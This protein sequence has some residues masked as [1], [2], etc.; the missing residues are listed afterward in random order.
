MTTTTSRPTMNEST[1]SQRWFAWLWR[2]LDS[3]VDQAVEPA[4]AR[5][6]QNLPDRVVEIG[7][8][9]GSTFKRYRPGTKVTAFE[10]NVFMHDELREAATKRGIEL[11]LRGAGAENM[12]LPDESQD[13]VVSSLT[14]CSVS[15]PVAVVSEIQRIL[16]PGGR[17]VFV[18]HIAAHDGSATAFAQ[19][20]LRRPWAALIGRC[21]LMPNTRRDIANAGFSEVHGDVAD[22]GSKLDPSRRTF[23]GYAVK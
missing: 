6:F 16:K 10:P 12:N 9:I 8:G 2:H 15:D 14:L 21:D 5:V 23:Y 22:L 4:K 3:G 18:E 20:M 7:P 13:V 17:F 1:R 11:D 19:K